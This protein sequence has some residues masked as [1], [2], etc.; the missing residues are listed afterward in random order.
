MKRIWI[1]VLLIIL[2]ILLLYS[3]IVV[4]AAQ[5]GVLL[6]LKSVI[7]SLLPFMILSGYIRNQLLGENLSFLKPIQK[8][9]KIPEGTEILWL[10]GMLGGYPVGAQC[11]NDA[12]TK[13][14]ITQAEGHRLL[15]FCCN[16][17]PSFIFGLV[18]TILSDQK[19]TWS[20]WLIQIITSILIG[21]YIPKSNSG[22]NPGK[23]QS[24]THRDIFSSCTR[25]M[26]TVCVWIILFRII[27]VLI[28]NLFT[29][30]PGDQSSILI[31][32]ILE[33]TNGCLSLGELTTAGARFVIA[34]V[35]LA[36]GGICVLIQTAA[37]T[38]NLGLGLYFPGKIAQAIL[39]FLLS[40]F[41]QFFLFPPKEWIKVHTLL[42]P[43][44]ILLLLC[45]LIYLRKKVVAIR[46]NMMYNKKKICQRG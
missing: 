7:P 34:S 41:L 37:V 15:A 4:C 36:F 8:L 46:I 23:L 38:K 21:L 10:L 26:S 11:I 42:L 44:T 6:C 22:P 17:G 9:C 30:H 24:H 31:C 5:E 14:H 33:L 2:L 27:L 32:G 39:C 40:Y 13:G 29:L 3:S 18:G 28:K 43:I 25:S 20:L 35:L 16:C 45:T 1:S 19:A 12:Y